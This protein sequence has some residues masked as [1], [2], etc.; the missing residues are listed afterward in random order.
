[1]IIQETLTAVIE[2]ACLKS[3]Q[4]IPPKLFASIHSHYFD[5]IWPLIE[6]KDFDKNPEKMIRLHKSIFTRFSWTAG[7]PEEQVLFLMHLHYVRVHRWFI[8]S[9][10]K[11]VMETYVKPGPVY[12]F[13][14]SIVVSI[15]RFVDSL[16]E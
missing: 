1:M 3:K 9:F 8:N 15:G 10:V 7:A 5:Q 2:R 4:K 12:R 16:Y 13:F 6:G 11:E 14:R